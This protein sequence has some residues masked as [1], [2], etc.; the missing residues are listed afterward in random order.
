MISV[1]VTGSLPETDGDPLEY[2]RVCEAVGKL[3]HPGCRLIVA[4][5][6]P[7]SGD[8]H[9][10]M[11]ALQSREATGH[12]L[13]KPF[14]VELIKAFGDDNSIERPLVR[15]LETMEACGVPGAHIDTEKSKESAWRKALRK[16]DIVLVLGG[17]DTPRV[18]C[19]MAFEEHTPVVAMIGLGGLSRSLFRETEQVYRLAGIDLNELSVLRGGLDSQEECKKF[20]A[21][22]LKIH[23]KKPWA[24]RHP[25]STAAAVGVVVGLMLCWT[26]VI[27]AARVLVPGN[28]VAWIALISAVAGALGGTLRLLIHSP[29]GLANV[30]DCVVNSLKSGLSSGFLVGALVAGIANVV[31]MSLDSKDQSMM[32]VYLLATCI[33]ISLG[34]FGLR[35]IPKLVEFIEKVAHH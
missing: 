3:L 12:S 14:N 34:Y 4:G 18:I 15:T 33:A 25:K 24:K 9:V 21:L 2:Q 30:A 5:S 22:L 17:N 7:N 31:K 6:E 28:W 8:H 10:F 35:G 29:H 16:A 27:S 23:S 11:G 26:A 1:F 19:E 20:L 32:A 13:S